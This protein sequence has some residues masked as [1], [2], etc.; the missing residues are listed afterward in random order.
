MKFKKLVSIYNV[1]R[2]MNLSILKSLEISIKCRK[3]ITDFN[4]PGHI[5]SLKKFGVK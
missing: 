3:I 5:S 4:S 2:N 1:L